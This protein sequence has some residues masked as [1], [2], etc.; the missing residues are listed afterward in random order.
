VFATLNDA[1]RN[2]LEKLMSSGAYKLQY[3]EAAERFVNFV[4]KMRN[5]GKVEAEASVLLRILGS[6]G[7]EISEDDRNRILACTDLTTLDRWIDRAMNATTVAE[8]LT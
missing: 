6:R 1:A 8:I 3:P 5:E 2:A 7:L 4:A